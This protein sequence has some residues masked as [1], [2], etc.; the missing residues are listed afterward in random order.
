MKEVEDPAQEVQEVPPAQELTPT[1]DGA[2]RATLITEARDRLAHQQVM[3]DILH[4]QEVMVA[5]LHILKD[6]LRGTEALVQD[7]VTLRRDT[8]VPD[9]TLMAPLP[10]AQTVPKT[11]NLTPL[12]QGSIHQIN[13]LLTVI[14]LRAP[15]P[16]LANT[17][18]PP[19]PPGHPRSITAPL[20]KRDLPTL[21]P[22]P[23]HPPKRKGDSPVVMMADLKVRNLG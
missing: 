16:L 21:Y 10:R 12:T 6:I 4:T 1:Q 17:R 23:D 8:A 22:H 11:L 9:R 2:I 18:V 13:P 5:T 15:L 14:I 19:P 3:V 7:L 20:D